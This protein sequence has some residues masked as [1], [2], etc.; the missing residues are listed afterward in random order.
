MKHAR[1]LYVNVVYVCHM[2]NVVYVYRYHYCDDIIYGI[3]SRM[4]YIYLLADVCRD[5]AANI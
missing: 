4:R 2:Q 1:F 5:L 3:T